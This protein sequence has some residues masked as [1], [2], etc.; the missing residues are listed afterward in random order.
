MKVLNECVA[1]KCL[2]K[3]L[4]YL[5]LAFFF[6]YEQPQQKKTISSNKELRHWGI[7]NPPN[8]IIQHVGVNLIIGAVDNKYSLLLELRWQTAQNVYQRV[9]AGYVEHGQTLHHH[10]IW[11]HGRIYRWATVAG[12]ACRNEDDEKAKI[13][14]HCFLGR[15]VG[16]RQLSPKET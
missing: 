15:C 13:F 4:F 9:S 8:E 1:W 12:E 16:G 3:S 2:K 10:S 7:T 5:N 14:S 11:G 6:I